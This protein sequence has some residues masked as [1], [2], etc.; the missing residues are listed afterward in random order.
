MRKRDHVTRSAALRSTETSALDAFI[1][2]EN[3][4]TGLS[5]KYLLENSTSQLG[6]ELDLS[7]KVWKYDAVQDPVFKTEALSQAK[8][9]DVVLVS[10]I[11]GTEP[12]SAV[13]SWL[14]EWIGDRAAKPCALVVWYDRR[15]AAPTAEAAA[16]AARY[17]REVADA[18]NL[19]FFSNLDG[20]PDALEGEAKLNGRNCAE[21]ACAHMARRRGRG[22]S[23]PRFAV[24]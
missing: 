15:D 9:S 2:Y 8:R 14:R 5:A 23:H 6:L 21:A 17:W 7:G 16:V 13:K 12:P 19:D 18:G 20:A 1:L 24:D 3:I 22:S 10:A 4:A 11:V